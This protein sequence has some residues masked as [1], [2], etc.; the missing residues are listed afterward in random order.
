MHCYME[1]RYLDWEKR[2]IFGKGGV[3][4]FVV[5]MQILANLVFRKNSKMRV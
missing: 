4:Y 5:S 1:L 2:K 3:S